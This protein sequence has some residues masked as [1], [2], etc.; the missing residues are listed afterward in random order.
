MKH[1]R[2]QSPGLFLPIASLVV[3]AFASV[4]VISLQFGL[5]TSPFGD[6][7]APKAVAVASPKSK[8]VARPTAGNRTKAKAH[9]GSERQPGPEVVHDEGKGVS[10]SRPG[11]TTDFEGP[12]GTKPGP[13]KSPARLA[14]EKK[15]EGSVDTP[16]AQSEMARWCEENQWPGEA[17]DHWKAV[18][19]L[20][21]DHALANKKL[22][23][24]RIG[25][26]WLTDAMVA[27]EAEQ[28][29]ADKR[30]KER[31]GVLHRMMHNR[32]KDA[33]AVAQKAVTELAEVTDPRAAQ[34][35]WHVFGG[36]PRHH[37]MVTRQLAKLESPKSSLTL[38]AVAAYSPDEKARR[39]AVDELKGREPIEFA[40]PLIALLGPELRYRISKLPTN[41]GEPVMKA[42]EVEDERFTKQFIYFASAPT[43]EL[44]SEAFGDCSAMV[45]WA[46]FGW[47]A[48]G[49]AMARELNKAEARMAKEAAEAQLQSD[50][51][52]VKAL[53]ERI[54]TQNDRV[55]SILAETTGNSFGFDR[56]A[57]N[58]WLDAKLGRKSI[59]PV[60]AAKITLTQFV[61]PIYQPSF[62]TVPPTPT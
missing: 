31:L 37:L 26:R 55:R 32:G 4:G 59:R 23:F 62:I 48:E 45:R 9:K 10:P 36:H 46:N 52:A 60:Q 47:T 42:L 58:G 54:R 51:A 44:T 25:K 21:P 38:A 14:Y 18:L 56:D 33:E 16:E 61:Q 30:W 1:G 43:T 17:L 57:W 34:A 11:S 22:G 29:K 7:E 39:A 27:E 12:A 41:P 28:E 50:I 19:R 6:K 5:I 20:A 49:R 15:A 35:L 3:A 40:E 2:S 13:P 24:K 53:N 8:P